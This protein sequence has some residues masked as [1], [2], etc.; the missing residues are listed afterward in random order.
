MKKIIALLLSVLMVLSM[1]ACGNKG[2]DDNKDDENKELTYEEKSALVYEN[3]LGEF[4]EYYA[5]AK[6]ATNVSERY[7][8]IKPRHASAST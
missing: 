8:L 7:A 1:V 2:Q 6:E 5:K 4:S 3:A